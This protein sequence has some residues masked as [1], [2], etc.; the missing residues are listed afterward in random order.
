MEEIR[1]DKFL[2]AIRA[3]KTRED[4]TK[5]CKGN[6]VHINGNDAKPSKPVKPG[7]IITVRK[8]EVTFTFK[9][10]VPIDKRQGAKL[11]GEYAENLTPAE[12]LEKMRRPVETFF[13]KRERGAGR[14]TKKERREMDDLWDKYFFDDED[15]DEDDD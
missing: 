5:A 7:D 3:F 15:Y 4:A 6:K 8:N 14:P 12:E 1:I 9:V 2:W 13:L 10:L 11:V